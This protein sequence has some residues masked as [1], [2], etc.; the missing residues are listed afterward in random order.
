MEDASTE[1]DINA[2]ESSLRRLKVRQEGIAQLGT[3]N[4][5]ESSSDH[6]FVA[7]VL[8]VIRSACLWSFVA[9][10]L[11][12]VDI[13]QATCSTLDEPSGEAQQLNQQAIGLQAAGRFAEAEPLFK[14]ALAIREVTLGPDHRYV[15]TSLNNLAELYR[16]EGRYAE[17][18]PLHRRALAIR[19]KALGP[20]HPY[21]A[22][23][24]GNLASLYK[25]QSRY[26]E[27]EP[28]FRR[29]LAIFENAR[30]RDDAYV[31]TTLNN[32]ADL[33]L[34]LARYAE[35]EQLNKRCLAIL[36]KTRGP[37]HLDVAASLNNL[38]ALY[39][40]EARYTEA[41]RLNKRSLAI[42]E[43]ALGADHP[44]VANSLN[45]LASL[46][47]DQSRYSE[48]ERLFQR[49]LAIYKKVLGPNHPDVAQSLTNLAVI[50]W[51]Q[52]RYAEAEPLFER[53]RVIWEKASGPDHPEVAVSLNNL[54]ELYATQG[55]YAE[56][57]PLDKRALEIR[58]KAFGPDHPDVAQSLTNLAGVYVAEARYIEAEPLYTRA[59][60]I[61]RKRF[62]AEH[63]DVAN[64]LNNLA[65]LYQ[66]QGRYAKAEPLDKHALKIRE[67]AL[68]PDH[69]DV[70]RSFNNLAQLYWTQGRYA[71]AEPLFE[72][73]LAVWR[74]TLG[75]DHPDVAT[76]LSN[77]AALYEDQGRYDEAEPLEKRALQIREKA[78]GPDHPD[79]ARSLNNLVAL[80]RAV[81]RWDEAV[82][83]CERARTIWEKALGPNHPD[84]A[85][86]LGMLA[87]L[88]EESG[89]GR[90]TEAEQL[91]ERS[92]AIFEKALGPDHPT[93]ATALNNLAGVYRAEGRYAEAERLYKSALTINEK[94]LGGDHPNVAGGL[95]NLATIYRSQ[96]QIGSALDL[97]QRAVQTLAKHLERGAG[98]RW[99]GGTTEQQRDRAYFEQ[100]VS[101]ADAVS[102]KAPLQRE[103]LVAES[104][105]VAQL[106]QISS[107]GQAVAGMSARFASGSDA[108]AA[109]VR[110][111]QDL[112]VQ[113]QQMES[114][115]VKAA[116]SQSANA[117]TLYK[118]LA[119][120]GRR[121]DM[122]HA[123]IAKDFP[124]YDELSNP[125]P[126][127]AEAAHALL[128]GDEAL[129]VYLATSEA[130]WLWVV[131]ADS[132]ALFRLEIGA[133]A[134]ETEV[135][136]LRT[137]L[138]RDN[139]GR[140]P[141]FDIAGS[142]DLY[143]KILEPA[144][145]MLAGVRHLII[146]PDGA[147]QSFPLGILVTKPPVPGEGVTDYRKI[148]WLARHFATT[149]LPTVSSLHALRAS[150]RPTKARAPFL[151]IGDPVLNGP[152]G[153]LPR[154][155]DTAEELKKLDKFLGAG[156]EDLL[157]AD[158]ARKPTLKAI[159]LTRYRV[160]A[161]ATHALVTVDLNG[162][163]MQ[164]AL[165]LTP[166][167]QRS[168]DDDGL[169]TASDVAQL[170]LDADWVILSACNTA[171]GDGK[172]GAEGLS[173]LAR[174]F[175]YA[176]ARSLLVSHWPVYSDAAV[177]IVTGML[178][179]LQ[180]SPD[181][182]R[183]EALRLAMI[184]L[185]DDEDQPR[186]AHPAQWAPFFLV[187]E[188]ARQ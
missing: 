84:V 20:D 77:L 87:L 63:P 55:R 67:K 86:S 126:L 107:P 160:I 158:R 62:G 31:A 91:Y 80:Y 44:S 41:E 156:P 146:V 109:V 183:A 5:R 128:A 139:V 163:L 185:L 176:G 10:L 21:V 64:G 168:A 8:R 137:T 1:N 105:S 46:Y 75:P 4:H 167:A 100:N 143:Q 38:A 148:A 184:D 65:H 40:A 33:Y 162:R 73:A 36:E 171:A 147:L 177:Q 30:G 28:L 154:L 149:V 58:E 56:A 166:P 9:A 85:T 110:E 135:T 145:T 142:H 130:T 108:L 165:V 119:V 159:D 106:A 69:P 120:A 7:H 124:D 32:L 182:T 52:G 79:V 35:A 181:L 186:L 70:A 48:A 152:P 16:A 173:G 2:L 125:K 131:R 113:Y 12:T 180:Q 49:A 82:E 23:S 29:A 22:V 140:L 45:S 115:L 161:F 57:E 99:R 102:R 155:P 188:G 3:N 39:R 74:N 60:A 133:Q 122:L 117:A 104:F 127:R 118:D 97:S 103:T 96:G 53:A 72:R 114:D 24:L 43:K 94:A 83:D 14:H 179:K 37:D 151:G 6:S 123:R 121:L 178:K 13:S 51:A 88:Y 19:E 98:Q 66:D 116:R 101:L 157:L 144:M 132:L 174:A 93:V 169:L 34:K 68:G 78:L 134:L 172:P 15:A 42:R 153:S 129:L 81:G 95:S 11:L 18:E 59:L 150:A 76:S 47:K 111:Q 17:A 90:Y 54:A 61:S 170:K 164:P 50:Y 187:G 112:A 138:V 136:A 89:K 27:A 141:P 25:D 175:F 71:E 26:T 92:L